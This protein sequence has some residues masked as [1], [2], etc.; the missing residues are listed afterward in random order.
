MRIPSN[1]L[2]IHRAC[3]F[4]ERMGCAFLQFVK[5]R[6]ADTS[7]IAAQGGI[8]KAKHFDSAR[9]QISSALGVMILLLGMT[10]TGAIQLNGQGGFPAVEIE[11][12][13][14]LSVLAAKLIAIETPASQPAPHQL[15]C[16]SLFFAEQAGALGVSH[17]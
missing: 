4:R 12:V 7:R 11:I 5:N 9:V 6:V 1:F 16:P 2:G 15:L 3:V 17:G 8:P 13:N 14:A 10:V